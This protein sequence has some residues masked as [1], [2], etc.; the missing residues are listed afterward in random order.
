MCLLRLTGLRKPAM[1]QF[2]IKRMSVF[3]VCLVCFVVKNKRMSVFLVCFVCF[4]V[5]NKRM[6][7]TN[8][9]ESAGELSFYWLR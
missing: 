6:N 1:L 9:I 3:L 4:V 5:K 8:N 2:C 7:W